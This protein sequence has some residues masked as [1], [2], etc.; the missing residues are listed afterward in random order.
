MSLAKKLA[1]A[2]R[3]VGPTAQQPVLQQRETQT[4][5]MSPQR[6]GAQTQQQGLG[7]ARG[8]VRA[9][10][11][12]VIG[13]GFNQMGGM[14]PASQQPGISTTNFAKSALYKKFAQMGGPGGQVQNLLENWERQRLGELR[15]G[16]QQTFFGP[17]EQQTTGFITPAQGIVQA[18][19][20]LGGDLFGMFAATPI[21]QQLLAKLSEKTGIDINK[22]YQT[23]YGGDPEAFADEQAALTTAMMQQVRERGQSVKAI[24]DA[25][26]DALAEI[27]AN[28]QINVPAPVWNQVKSFIQG[29]S[30]EQVGL[31]VQQMT[32]MFPQ[33]EAVISRVDPG[34]IGDMTPFVNLTRAQNEGVFDPAKFN[35]LITEFKQDYA[36]GKFPNMPATVAAQVN[37]YAH[38]MLGDKF[39]PQ[40]ASNLAQA[41]NAYVQSGLAPNIGSALQAISTDDPSGTTAADPRYAIQQANYI[42]QVAKRNGID[43]RLLQ[44]AGQMAV[45]NGR[46]FNQGLEAVIT[47]QNIRKKMP[48]PIG[49][50]YADMAVQQMLTQGNAAQDRTLSAVFM[51]A[52][53]E[54]KKEIMR[55]V[56][57]AGERDVRRRNYAM[58]RLRRRLAV[59]ERDPTVRELATKMSPQLHSR[60]MQQFQTVNP[61]FQG[62]RPLPKFKGVKGQEDLLRR[63]RDNDLSGLDPETMTAAM[64]PAQVGRYLAAQSAGELAGF[65]ERPG[66]WRRHVGAV[67][68]KQPFERP[69]PPSPRWGTREAGGAWRRHVGNL[70]GTEAPEPV[71]PIERAGFDY[72]RAQPFQPEQMKSVPYRPKY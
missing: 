26:I 72:P 37:T 49:Q 58:D 63:L 10:E 36:Q 32:Q 7:N 31:A 24:G 23:G 33:L 53:A 2:F 17:S 59:A 50:Q 44:Q 42:S 30:P 4:Q 3:S 55:L 48:G 29:W 35:Q 25:T 51:G 68:G 12:N 65:Q 64:D 46:T 11:P 47:A 41:A 66:A 18:G 6:Q 69:T 67:R 14:Q 54:G 71:K 9:T 19:T 52:P 16:P 22:P 21:F 8:M 62:T 1:N 40:H 45:Q 60:L 70:R 27:A 39:Q 5:I 38:E 57:M 20:A 13:G 34:Y 43:R 61:T 15:G 28:A 56:Q